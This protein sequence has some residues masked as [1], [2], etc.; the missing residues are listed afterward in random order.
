M[1]KSSSNLRAEAFFSS[2][3]FAGFISSFLTRSPGPFPMDH[4][5]SPRLGAHGGHLDHVHLSHIT[6]P[7]P[8]PEWRDHSTWQHPRR[9]GICKRK[10]TN[11]NELEET[12]S[13]CT[14]CFTSQGASFWNKA[15]E[16]RGVMPIKGL[17]LKTEKGVSKR[18]M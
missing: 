11:E 1:I 15:K 9:R 5:R 13:S 10:R 6:D 17:I 2:T 8:T 12:N 3:E 7:P 16:L 4:R 14:F 18:G